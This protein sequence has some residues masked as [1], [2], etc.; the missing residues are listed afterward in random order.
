[1]PRVG[2]TFE[3]KK[4]TVTLVELQPFFDPSN[5]RSLM[6]SYKLKDGTFEGPTSH[7]W[8]GR[9]QDI[10]PRIEEVVEYYLSVVKP[11]TGAKS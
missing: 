8:M 6:V 2:E 10:R 1:V 11:L 4:I 9:N 5:R 7:F 3:H